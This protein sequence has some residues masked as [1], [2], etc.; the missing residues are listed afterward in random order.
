[1]TRLKKKRKFLLKSI[2]HVF[3][4]LFTSFVAEPSVFL[5]CIIVL[6]IIKYFVTARRFDR[7]SI[8]S[9]EMF[10]V[11]VCRISLNLFDDVL[12]EVLVE[13]KQIFVGER[14]F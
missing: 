12:V 8:S 9:N 3:K 4:D 6:M 2:L 7:V 1:M 13:M 11:K 5:I 14:G 10:L